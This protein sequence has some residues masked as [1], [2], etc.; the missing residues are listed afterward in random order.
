[1]LPE[2]RKLIAIAVG[3]LLAGAPMM[4]L[5]LW[6]DGLLLRQGAYDTETFARRSIRLANS[7]L[8]AALA[9][10]DTLANEGVG[11]CSPEQVELVRAAGL[12]LPWVKQVAVLGAAGQ[13]LCS[14]FELPAVGP[15]KVVAQRP[16]KDSKSVIEVVE[17]ENRPSRMVRLR[18]P[19]GLGPNS[20][21]ALFPADVLTARMFF[22]SPVSGAYGQLAL[23][24]GTVVSDI[25]ERPQD[26]EAA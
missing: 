9:T 20:L 21:S 2:P 12:S 6:I 5:D 15:V 24:D 23:L 17:L 3:V 22:Q 18:R 1:M 10:L 14:D 25:G 13:P 16:V 11:G 19:T 7:R 8:S 4:A 26:S